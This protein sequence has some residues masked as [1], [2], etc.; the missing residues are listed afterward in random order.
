MTLEA[1]KP[2][3]HAAAHFRIPRDKN[4]QVL[5]PTLATANITLAA[6]MT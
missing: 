4:L 5:V 1:L 3:G 2:V 6:F